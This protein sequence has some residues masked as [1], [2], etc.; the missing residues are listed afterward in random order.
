MTQRRRCNSSFTESLLSADLLWNINL[1]SVIKQEGVI[2]ESCL[3]DCLCYELMAL[4]KSVYYYYYYD[5]FITLFS[6]RFRVNEFA[7]S[8]DLV[9]YYSA[10]IGQHRVL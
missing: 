2:V 6:C 9:V 10:P 7:V 1:P 3:L 4:Y 8:C 5:H